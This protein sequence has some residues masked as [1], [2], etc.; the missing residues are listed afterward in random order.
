MYQ[1]MS[2]KSVL[3]NASIYEGLNLQRAATKY[4]HPSSVGL[5]LSYD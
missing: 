4:C 3:V 5:L 1:N 2:E